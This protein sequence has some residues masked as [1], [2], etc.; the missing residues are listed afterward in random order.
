MINMRDIYYKWKSEQSEYDKDYS[1]EVISIRHFCNMF[2]YSNIDFNYS[3]DGICKVFSDLNKEIFM[4]KE[5]NN[6][7]QYEP[8][9]S[10]DTFKVSNILCKLLDYCNY[11]ITYNHIDCLIVVICYIIKMITNIILN[12]KT[13]TKYYYNANTI[14]NLFKDFIDIIINYEEILYLSDNIINSISISIL[15]LNDKI[16][17]IDSTNPRN[18]QLFDFRSFLI[19]KRNDLLNKLKLERMKIK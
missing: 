18:I 11:F 10:I 4:Y 1:I 3:S 8:M 2:P 9:L 5:I 12:F 13:I 16:E 7:D 17:I 15:S 19:N 6:L 14:Y